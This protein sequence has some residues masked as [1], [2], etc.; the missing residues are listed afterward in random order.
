[1][2]RKLENKVQ[3]NIKKIYHPEPVYTKAKC[4]APIGMN[5]PTKCSPMK[6]KPTL[7]PR[8]PCLVVSG[9]AT[10]LA[11]YV[12]VRCGTKCVT[13]AC[14]KRHLARE[15][16]YRRYAC[17]HCATKHWYPAQVIKHCKH[18]HPGNSPLT[19]SYYFDCPTSIFGQCVQG[20]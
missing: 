20:M 15:L 13:R 4:A 9:S 6:A 10:M 11:T 1:M 14:M 12:C 8:S 19:P 5:S 17:P 18:A 7:V 3:E 2:Y 16:R